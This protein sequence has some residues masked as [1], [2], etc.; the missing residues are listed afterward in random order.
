MRYMLLVKGDSAPGV[1][2]PPEQVTAMNNYAAD[3]AKSGVLLAAEGLRDSS[4]GARVIHSD[5]TR[6]VVD[7]PFTESKELVGGFWLIDVSSREEAIEW[8]RRCPVD[9]SMSR[10]DEAVVEVRRVLEPADVPMLD[11]D[12]RADAEGFEVSNTRD[13]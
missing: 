10:T 11:D 6:R 12:Q 7:G 5:G 2:P 9:T 3:L 13:V 1:M 4:T 8:A